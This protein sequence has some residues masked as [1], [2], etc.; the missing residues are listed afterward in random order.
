MGNTVVPAPPPSSPLA[1]ADTWSLV[2]DAYTRDLLPM[3][4]SFALDALRLA[5]LPQGARIVDVA[6]GPGTLAL[7]AA[8]KGA[9]VSALDFS[10]AML[11]ILKR[12]AGD[13][14][15]FNMDIREGDGQALP[16]D[17]GAYD[18]AF[19]MFGL[20][21]FPDRAAGFRE[22]HRVLRPGRR[23]VVSSWAPFEGV[24]ALVFQSIKKILP[25]LPMGQGKMP[26]GDLDSCKQEMESAGFGKV[27]V[28]TVTHSGTGANLAEFWAST[29]RNSAPVALLRRNMGAAWADV[30]RGVY[31][32]L[33]E[34]MGEGPV[35][36]SGTSYLT[37]GT[38]PK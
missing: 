4:E 27:E 28:H 25:D 30:D 24:F 34:A 8:H 33:A 9:K 35:F 6:A 15:I 31:K 13:A 21:F 23:A 3:F 5:E 1:L 19:S 22:L 14:G 38:K 18:G 17:G 20:M 26:L 37:V 12:R 36:S 16:F 32:L 10:P 2:S 7:L 29:Q 11:A